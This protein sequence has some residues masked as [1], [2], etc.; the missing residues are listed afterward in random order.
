MPLNGVGSGLSFH[1]G[2]SE[3]P[4]A[5]ENVIES[6]KSKSNLGYHKISKLGSDA[7]VESANDT[8]N[9]AAPDERS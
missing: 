2:P 7:L 3:R 8:E 4:Y 5:N 1:N 6:T 9:G